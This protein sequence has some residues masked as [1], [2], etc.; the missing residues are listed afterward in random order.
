MRE[1]RLD[2]ELYHE[3]FGSILDRTEISTATQSVRV[4][5]TMMLTNSAS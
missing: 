5:H 1:M 4:T 2:Q 3:I